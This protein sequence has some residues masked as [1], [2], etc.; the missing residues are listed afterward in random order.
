MD[1]CSSENFRT[2]SNEYIKVTT[3]QKGEAGALSSDV[4]INS[5]KNISQY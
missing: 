1:Y 3:F 5:L 4:E 2:D